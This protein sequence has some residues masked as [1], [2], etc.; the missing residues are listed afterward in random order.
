MIVSLKAPFKIERSG[1]FEVRARRSRISDNCDCG[2]ILRCWRNDVR[3]EPSRCL[4]ISRNNPAVSR[5]YS[6]S[7]D[8]I[9]YSGGMR[10]GGARLKPTHVPRRHHSLTHRLDVPHRYSRDKSLLNNRK[11]CPPS[12]GKYQPWETGCHCSERESMRQSLTKMSGRTSVVSAQH[13]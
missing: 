1:C 7:R 9:R 6:S 8:W 3:Y 10:W 4:N 5:N 12:P 2:A 13:T 11:P